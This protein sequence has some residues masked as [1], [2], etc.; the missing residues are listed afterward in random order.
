MTNFIKQSPFETLI[1]VNSSGQ[2]LLHLLWKQ[3]VHYRVHNSPALVLILNQVNPVHTLFSNIHFNIILLS[4]PT[5]FVVH[6]NGTSEWVVLHNTTQQVG[7]TVRLRNAEWRA[8]RP[9]N[10]RN[11]LW[12]RI[13]TNTCKATHT[14]TQKQ[15][16]KKARWLSSAGR[17]KT[18]KYKQT[19]HPRR[20]GLRSVITRVRPASYSRGRRVRD[21]LFWLRV[22]EVFLSPSS[23]LQG[24]HQIR[25]QPLPSTSFSIHHSLVTRRYVV[26]AT[27]NVVK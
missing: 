17:Q 26:W 7:L 14:Q 13:R 12:R 24:M 20:T 27:D 11:D 5:N 15:T 1:M 23:N 16:N 10:E 22:F 2:W 21:R 3:T 18:A 19:E 25:P 4:T 9:I 8:S 6:R